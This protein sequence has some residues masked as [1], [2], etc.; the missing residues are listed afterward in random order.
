MITLMRKIAGLAANVIEN[1]WIYTHR[2]V[3]TSSTVMLVG[4]PRSGTTWIM[5]IIETLGNYRIVFEPFNP[6]F[7]PITRK[8]AFTLRF[9]EP[10]YRPY[11][12][13]S[14]KDPELEKY[15]DLV[16][17]GHVS[18]YW[19][20]PPRRLLRNLKWLKSGKVL[21]KDVWTTR[22]LPWIMHRFRHKTKNFFLLIRHPCAVIESQIRTCVG[23]PLCFYS[24]H[25]VK[26]TILRQLNAIEEL[27]DKIDRIC[28][29]LE[30][31][32]RHEELLASIWAMDYYVPLFYNGRNYY[33]IIVY[34]DFVL[35]SHQAIERT[36]ELLGFRVRVKSSDISKLFTYPSPTAKDVAG[37][38]VD[39]IYKWKKRLSRQQIE[40]IL[41]IIHLFDITFYNEN[42]EPNYS[43]II[44]WRP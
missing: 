4:V 44:N 32:S 21:V 38:V 37:R 15:I 7:Y 31:I 10:V 25:I 40:S 9:N 12:P 30:N 17:R 18:G 41:R 19:F 16:L 1:A 28:P 20:S 2:R 29:K 43:E 5:E 39:N 6:G 36:I 42:I 13:I 23:N 22:L 26:K 35:H 34:E 14:Q 24:N 33:K 27:R 3:N 11:L 8:Y